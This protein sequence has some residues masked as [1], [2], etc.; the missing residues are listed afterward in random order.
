M[1][2]IADL[3]EAML[4]S[5]D[6]N[7]T[8]GETSEESADVAA[9]KADINK[10]KALSRTNEKRWHTASAELESLRQER[11]ATAEEAAEQIRAETR[12][13]VLAEVAPRLVEAE[14]KVQAAQAEI[15]INDLRFLD[16]SQF[17]MP[18]GTVDVELVG[19]FIASRGGGKPVYPQNIGLGRQ[20]GSFKG[21]PSQPLDARNR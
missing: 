6:P 11:T 1:P 5:T 13:A 10:W 15:Q 17:I 4:D 12:N 2:A 14:I 9:L 3:L 18:E 20:G 7:P 21:A 8:A 19:E 16:M